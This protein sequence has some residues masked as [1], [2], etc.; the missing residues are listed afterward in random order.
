MDS[1]AVQTGGAL[2]IATF[3]LSILY[4]VYLTLNHKHVR[5][6][7]CGSIYEIGFDVDS[8]ASSEHAEARKEQEEQ[9]VTA[10]HRLDTAISHAHQTPQAQATAKEQVATDQ[11]LQARLQIPSY[12]RKKFTVKRVANRVAP[13][14]E[15]QDIP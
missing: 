6:N 4:K 8:A 13:L 10:N 12:G 2:G 7:C 11:A 9:H 15:A 3:V 1:A 5:I 14:D